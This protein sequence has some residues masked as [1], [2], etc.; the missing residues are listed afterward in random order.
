MKTLSVVAAGLL[1]AIIPAARAA[2]SPS[3]VE[4]QVDAL[5]RSLG[6]KNDDVRLKAVK[7]LG[8]LG[9]DAAK[10][11]PALIGALKLPNEDVRLNVVLTLAKIGKPAVD[12]VA[13]AIGERN[14]DV[15]YYLVWALA[16][17][18]PDARDKADVV[19]KLLADPSPDIR[20]RAAHC[21]GRIDPPPDLVVP[22]LVKL[23][24]DHYDVRPAASEAL[25]RIGAPAVPALVKA[26]TSREK[27]VPAE[28]MRALGAI[29]PDAKDAVPGLVALMKADSW[30]TGHVTECLVKIGPPALPALVEVTN[31][32]DQRLRWVAV[33][34]IRKIDGGAS[35]RALVDALKNTH[36]DVRAGAA[37]A[38]GDIGISD[39]GIVLALAEVLAKDKH[40]YPRQQAAAALQ[41]M[42]GDARVAEAALTRALGDDDLGVRRAAYSALGVV[43]PDVKEVAVRLLRS[44]DFRFR[45]NVAAGIL[46]HVGRDHPEANKVL[47][48]ALK[49][50]EP[51]DRFYAAFTLGQLQITP[52]GTLD[53]LVEALKDRKPEVRELSLRRLGQLATLADRV[54]PELIAALKDENAAVCRAACWA[55]K[56][57]RADP[58]AAMEALGD[59][60]LTDPDMTIQRAAMD[61]L[62]G[63]FQEEA[64]PYFLKALTTSKDQ[65]VR[66]YASGHLRAGKTVDPKMIPDLLNVVK[67]DDDVNVRYQSAEAIAKAGVKAIPALVELVSSPHPGIPMVAMQG[68]QPHGGRAKAAVP[69]LVEVM[70][71]GDVGI[72]WKAAETLGTIGPAAKDSLDALRD[73][74]ANGVPNLRLAADKAI[75]LIEDK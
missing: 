49:E 16:M 34:S 21:L 65:N 45:V 56:F 38:L 15:R 66:Y 18:G 13:A 53:V 42:G 62:W 41:R 63:R 72:R 6:D 20:R 25:G 14:P 55:L 51:S 44:R 52:E 74:A 54:Q 27:D 29:G 46:E 37:A 10:A 2:D 5:V 50:K 64:A 70:K 35:V 58:R 67:N 71:N 17:I 73:A 19:A 39:K 24:G 4:K 22:G 28:A 30:V 47:T 1:L 43:R 26:L 36:P 23:L 33:Q 61:S 32:D 8:E 40:E 60:L 31:S 3:A 57:T 9:P 7:A 69:A 48:D 75:K 59:R 12:P 68:L 11:V